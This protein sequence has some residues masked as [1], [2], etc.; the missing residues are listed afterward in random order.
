[1]A[2]GAYQWSQLALD[3]DAKTGSSARSRV[4]FIHSWFH[5][6][7][8]RPFA[9]SIAD[10]LEAAERGL[11]SGDILFGCYN[12]SAHVVYLAAAGAPLEQVIERGREHHGRNGRRVVNA[13]FHCLHEMQIAKALAGKTRAPLSLTDDEVDE[14]RD[15]GSICVTDYYNQIGYYLVS[16]VK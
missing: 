3:Y 12:L 1:D 5:N 11:S 8:V 9:T 2:A 6:H 13:A 7:W 14:E 10:S 15:L 4:A 16:R